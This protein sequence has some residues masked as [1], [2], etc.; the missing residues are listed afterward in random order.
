MVLSMFVLV[1]Y[2]IIVLIKYSPEIKNETSAENNPFRTSGDGRTISI[3][4]H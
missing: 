2:S 4:V 3:R 1:Y